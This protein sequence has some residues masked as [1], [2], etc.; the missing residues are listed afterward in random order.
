MQTFFHIF[1][2][3]KKLIN[4]NKYVQK[5]VLKNVQ[6]NVTK[7]RTKKRNTMLSTLS[8][9]FICLGAFV[10]L[11]IIVF[12]Y[13]YYHKIGYWEGHRKLKKKN[14]SRKLEIFNSI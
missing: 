6:K 4:N 9:I 1:F 11:N 14:S 13:Q 2:I 8:I 5:N 7:K 3:C 12:L 10:L